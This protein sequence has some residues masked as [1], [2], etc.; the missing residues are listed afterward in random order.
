MKILATIG[1]E[2]IKSENLNYIL[3][4]TNFV[5]LNSSKFY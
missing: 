2:T 3:K 1:P 5:R 4:N